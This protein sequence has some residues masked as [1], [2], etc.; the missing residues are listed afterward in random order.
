MSEISLGII[1]AG[2]TVT[3]TVQWLEISFVS[4]IFDVYPSMG[5]IARP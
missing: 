3:F 5:V 1:P 4:G 2:V